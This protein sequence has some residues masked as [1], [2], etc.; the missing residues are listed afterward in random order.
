MGR[1]YRILGMSEPQKTYYKTCHIFH[2][3]Y[4]LIQI[5]L[6]CLLFHVWILTVYV[7]CAW[8]P[9]VS[10]L[11]SG[12]GVAPAPHLLKS[13]SSGSSF[14]PWISILR[15]S[16]SVGLTRAPVRIP[17]RE[18]HLPAT[19]R[20]G[21]RTPFHCRA[22]PAPWGWRTPGRAGGGAGDGPYRVR[23]VSSRSPGSLTLFI[24]GPFLSAGSIVVSLSLPFS[25]SK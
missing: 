6:M 2:H 20:V 22:P 24:P 12:R 18:A 3:T 14:Y 16:P 1:V 8:R 11:Q 7:R 19:C 5:P 21:R 25:C 10:V 4:F 15:L 17:P 23:P 9:G 13:S